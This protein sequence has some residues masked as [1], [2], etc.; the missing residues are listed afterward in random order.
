[1][2]IYKIKKGRHLLQNHRQQ[3]KIKLEHESPLN[4]QGE[5]APSQVSFRV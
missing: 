1:M 4:W 2:I 3:N 5:K